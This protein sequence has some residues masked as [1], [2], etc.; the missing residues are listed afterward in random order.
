MLFHIRFL[1]VG[2]AGVE[3][4][5][6]GAYIWSE[7]RDNIYKNAMLQTSSCL[8]RLLGKNRLPSAQSTNYSNSTVALPTLQMK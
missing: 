4:S 5:M 2:D 6:L 1:G 8:E 3:G 7:E